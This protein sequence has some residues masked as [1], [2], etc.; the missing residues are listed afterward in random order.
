MGYVEDGE[1]AFVRNGFLI[2]DEMIGISCVRIGSVSLF[3]GQRGKAVV[4]GIVMSERRRS[5]RFSFSYHSR[6]KT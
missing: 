5:L 3:I 1:G 2:W 6:I 4:V